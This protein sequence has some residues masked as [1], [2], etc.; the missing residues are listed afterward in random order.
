[1]KRVLYFL[2]LVI[3]GLFVGGAVHAENIYVEDH[4]NVLSS[5]T[6]EEIFQYN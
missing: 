1:M 5:E 4:A 2:S 3:F 6:K